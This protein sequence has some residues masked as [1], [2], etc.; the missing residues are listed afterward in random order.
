MW[1]MKYHGQRNAKGFHIMHALNQMKTVLTVVPVFLYSFRADPSTKETHYGCFQK[2]ITGISRG[3]IIKKTV[4][5][6]C[7][8]Y[9][10]NRLSIISTSD[11]AEIIFCDFLKSIQNS[12]FDLSFF[13]YVLSTILLSN[14]TQRA[15]RKS[16]AF[17]WPG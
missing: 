2:E 11:Y 13:F 14:P 16:A 17:D 6:C 12:S 8:V 5:V 7:R 15:Y 4:C 3:R 10:L 9:W 1:R